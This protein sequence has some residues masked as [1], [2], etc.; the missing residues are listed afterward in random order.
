MAQKT[1]GSATVPAQLCSS[2]ESGV[3]HSCSGSSSAN[4]ILRRTIELLRDH[5]LTATREGI[6]EMRQSH[7][8]QSCSPHT[9]ASV[10]SCTVMRGDFQGRGRHDTGEGQ[11]YSTRTEGNY[12][13]L[14]P[15]C[16]KPKSHSKTVDL[17][18]SLEDSC[19]LTRH[20]S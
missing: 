8:R 6:Q 17:Q 15:S 4:R 18:T 1:V 3:D 16:L 19:S 9:S 13:G 11:F 2:F 10:E 5:T 14:R 12:E 7:V 20:H